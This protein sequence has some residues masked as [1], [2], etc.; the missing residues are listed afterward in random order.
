M[1]PALHS[2]TSSR[3]SGAV[4]AAIRCVRGDSS[5]RS[6]RRPVRLPG[7]RRLPARSGAPPRDA[8]DRNGCRTRPWLPQC[9][10]T[11]VSQ[12]GRWTMY[13]CRDA[14]R[15]A[16]PPVSGPGRP[17][18]A[19]RPSRYPPATALGPTVRSRPERRMHRCPASRTIPADAE[20]QNPR[21]PRS[22]VRPGHRAGLRVRLRWL[23][24]IRRQ[25]RRALPARRRHGRCRRG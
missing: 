20:S 1:A 25:C 4:R 23:P 2:S 24:A 17:G 13:C 11:G 10:G 18:G 14:V 3:T 22:S 5:A 12:S 15:T 16:G 21:R 19:P 7:H 9:A 8:G 6:V